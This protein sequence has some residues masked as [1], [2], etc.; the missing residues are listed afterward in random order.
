M[1]PF[2][3]TLTFSAFIPFQFSLTVPLLIKQGIY[4]VFSNGMSI[5]NLSIKSIFFL[6]FTIEYHV[7]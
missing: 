2:D 3:R 6:I 5:N 7:I 4:V 1:G